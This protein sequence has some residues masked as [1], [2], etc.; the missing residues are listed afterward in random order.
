MEYNFLNY[1]SE[2]NRL[3]WTPYFT[4]GLGVVY[5]PNGNT[6]QPCLP[7]GVGLRFIFKEN[8]NL[9]IE[10]A[11][12]KMFTDALDNLDGNSSAVNSST[13]DWYIYNGFTVSY[14][15]YDVYCPKPRR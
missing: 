10:A 11:A 15:F 9:G 7:V 13:K 3:K 12:R 8:W 1:R 2:T 4:G 5:S 6:V 14:T